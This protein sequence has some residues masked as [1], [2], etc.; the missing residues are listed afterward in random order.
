[1]THTTVADAHT[2]HVCYRIIPAVT[3]ASGNYQN[4][5]TY[6]ATATF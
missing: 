2:T 1:M 4:S 3:N 5:I 6:T